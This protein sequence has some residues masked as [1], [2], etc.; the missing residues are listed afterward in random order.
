MALPKWLRNLRGRVS[1]AI[2]RR[3]LLKIAWKAQLAGIRPGISKKG[4]V[5]I[6]RRALGEIR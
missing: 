6:I 4:L 1:E 2:P 3:D 5:T